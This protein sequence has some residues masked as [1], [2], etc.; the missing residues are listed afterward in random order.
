MIRKVSLWGTDHGSKVI[1]PLV[2]EIWATPFFRSSDFDEKLE[3]I[4]NFHFVQVGCRFLCFLGRGI[5]CN[6]QFYHE[7]II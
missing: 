4:S 1:R 7:T 3:N 5:D 2:F 6:Y